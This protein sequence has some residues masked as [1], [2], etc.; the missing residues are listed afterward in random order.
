M[1]RCWRNRAQEVTLS[2]GGEC[3]E[4]RGRCECRCGANG[5]E[6]GEGGE[7]GGE[8]TRRREDVQSGQTRSCRRATWPGASRSRSLLCALGSSDGQSIRLV[9]P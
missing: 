6:K 1:S 8:R 4:G 9:R 2:R 3:R 5:V 7:V